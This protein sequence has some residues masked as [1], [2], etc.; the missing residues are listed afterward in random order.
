MADARRYASLA[1]PFR[2]HSGGELHGAR[3]AYET[4]GELNAN[5]DNALIIFT[6]LS[7]GAHAASSDIDDSEGWWETIVGPGKAINSN[8]FFVICV[9]SLGSCHG[10]TG[11]ASDNPATG[12]PWQTDFPELSIEDIANSATAVLDKENIT[13]PVTV[14]GPSMGGLTALAFAI[15]HPHRTGN[16][17]LISC[18][19]HPTPL[20]TAIRSLQREMIR[21]DR[22]WAGGHYE[23]GQEPVVGMRLAR[24]LGMISYR[25]AREWEER[26]HRE[27]VPGTE[28]DSDPFGVRFQVESYLE[29]HAEK[30]VGSFDANCYLYLSR[31]MD[32][33]DVADYGG[34][35]QAGLAHIKT[36]RALVIGVETDILFPLYQQVALAEGLRDQGVSVVFH[37]LP[38]IQGHD[39]FL[40]DI[41]R[42][43][44][45]IREFLAGDPKP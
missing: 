2:M 10:S 44:P 29:A 19:T 1:D 9:N 17:L 42:F 11:P 26:F 23:E 43:G 34:T 27:R 14:V 33:F 25:S 22:D 39:A 20:T 15:N 16:L 32:M 6:G 3:L 12:K 21:T 18:A 30:F 8:R 31:A 41:E 28:R 45:A 5:R 37:A 38:S 4:W 7:P 36:R 24:K 13:G 40:V 35:D